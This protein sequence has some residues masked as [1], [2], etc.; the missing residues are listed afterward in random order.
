MKKKK[1]KKKLS[2]GLAAACELISVGPKEPL[3]K[4]RPKIYK[5]AALS[6]ANYVNHGSQIMSMRFLFG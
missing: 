2:N 4:F 3:M 5:L 6:R 1:K